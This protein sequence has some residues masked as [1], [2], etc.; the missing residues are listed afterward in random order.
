VFNIP[1]KLRWVYKHLTYA[2]L[3]S[4]CAFEISMADIL[5]EDK[6]QDRFLDFYTKNGIKLALKKY[7]MVNK[8]REKG[9]NYIDVKIG[10]R[11]DGSDYLVIFEPPFKKDRFIAE[12]VVRKT[13]FK[14]IFPVLKIEWLCLQNIHGN[15]S[16]EKPRLP[17]Q[18][19]PGLGLGKE[20]LQLIMLMGIRLKFHA[21]LNSPQYFHNA[22]IYSVAFYFDNPRDFGRLKALERLMKEEGL[23]LSQFAWAMEEGR[24]YKKGEKKPYKWEPAIQILPLRTYLENRYGT[25]DYWHIVKKYSERYEFFLKK[26]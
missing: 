20:A 6:Q 9:F 15:F 22:Y 17:G 25:E 16:K 19:F 13:S 7:G 11:E 23:T 10:K 5:G 18:N 14:D 12:L 1:L 24:V 8:L 3:T 26:G 4:G 2:E 21:L